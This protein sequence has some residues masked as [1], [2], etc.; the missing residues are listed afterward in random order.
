[1]IE[2]FTLLSFY[3]LLSFVLTNCDHDELKD[4]L[5]SSAHKEIELVDSPI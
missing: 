1:M 4:I 3:C 5:G 2:Y